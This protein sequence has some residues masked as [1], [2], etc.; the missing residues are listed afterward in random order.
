MFSYQLLHD[1]S[2][3]IAEVPACGFEAKE[4]TSYPTSAYKA[5]GMTSL[6]NI[7]NILSQPAIMSIYHNPEKLLHSTLSVYLVAY[8]S[9]YLELNFR[10]HPRILYRLS[11]VD[12]QISSMPFQ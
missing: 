5:S 11:L 3:C 12:E 9:M 1:I 6:N 8:G 10:F 2:A 4:D 7:E